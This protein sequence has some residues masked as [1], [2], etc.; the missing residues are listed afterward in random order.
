MLG[1]TIGFAGVAAL[2]VLVP[3]LAGADTARFFVVVRNVEESNGVHSEMLEE[4]RKL[5]TA[6][7]ARHPELTLTPPAA[8]DADPNGD[9]E[10]F[11]AA[12]R[13][14]KL[15]A[16][17]L[18]L[19]ILEATKSIEPPPAGKP[20][21]VLKRGVR[22]SVFGTTLPDKVMA[23]GGDGD[24]II[25]AEIRK[26]DDEEKESHKLI[27]EATRVAITQAVDMTVTKLTLP[28]TAEKKARKKK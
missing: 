28:P 13:A 12:L 8:L 16:L 15:R 17:E 14:H 6:E 20:F 11:K 5:F 24:A 7:L 23:I 19:R 18:T 25:A 10:A 26:T 4:A 21:R 3:T 22:L 1:R 27:A 9:N 2:A